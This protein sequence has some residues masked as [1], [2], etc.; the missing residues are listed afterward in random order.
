[1]M[2]NVLGGGFTIG[3]SRDFQLALPPPEAPAAP[4][5]GKP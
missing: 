4:A 3:R 1:M 5:K 2:R